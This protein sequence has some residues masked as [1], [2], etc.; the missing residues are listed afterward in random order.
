MTQF[1][2]V[3]PAE[4][5]FGAQSQTLAARTLVSA[6]RVGCPSSRRSAVGLVEAKSADDA[7]RLFEDH[8]HITVFPGDGAGITKADNL[9]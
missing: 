8:P 1:E 5:P 7:A 4:L 9:I 2:G 3:N 6:S